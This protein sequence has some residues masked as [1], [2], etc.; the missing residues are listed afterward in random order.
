VRHFPNPR[1]PRLSGLESCLDTLR[2]DPPRWSLWARFALMTL[3]SF[4]L[5]VVLL[6]LLYNLTGGLAR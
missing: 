2:R 5:G 4:A 1:A 3:A 6:V